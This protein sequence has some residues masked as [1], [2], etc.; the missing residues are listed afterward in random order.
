MREPER[1]DTVLRRLRDA[2]DRSFLDGVPHERETAAIFTAILSP[3]RALGMS[4]VAE[5]VE[6]A[7]QL[8]FLG[9]KGCGRVQGYDLARPMPASDVTQDLRDR[10]PMRQL[11][12]A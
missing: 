10:G 4:A 2:G 5:G 1:A 3:A 6:T 7:G 8:E 9:A 12:A 11:R